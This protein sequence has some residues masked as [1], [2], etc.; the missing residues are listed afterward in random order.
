MRIFQVVSVTRLVLVMAIVE[1]HVNV[2]NFYA[3]D[4]D[5]LVFSMRIAMQSID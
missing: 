2:L 1:N 3:E 4:D 5:K